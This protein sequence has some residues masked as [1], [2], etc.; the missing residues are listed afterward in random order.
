VPALTRTMARTSRACDEG[1][2]GTAIQHCYWA[3]LM[4]CV[5]VGLCWGT[6]PLG[7]LASLLGHRGG[8]HK[9]GNF[10]MDA[11]KYQH[12]IVCGSGRESEVDRLVVEVRRAVYQAGRVSQAVTRVAAEVACLAGVVDAVA[13]GYCEEPA[14]GIGSV[15]RCV[16]DGRSSR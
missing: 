2:E 6:F 14:L 13:A 4:I 5:A 12:T 8:V 1:R 15:P 11:Q 10:V 7:G 9:K 16:P 3:G